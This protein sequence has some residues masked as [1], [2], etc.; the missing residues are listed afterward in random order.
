MTAGAAVQPR[1][2]VRQQADQNDRVSVQDVLRIA[3]PVRLAAFIGDLEQFA[4]YRRLLL[5][6]ED[7]GLDVVLPHCLGGGPSRELHEAAD[8]RHGVLQGHGVLMHVRSNNSC[9]RPDGG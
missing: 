7:H 1:S 6:G 2:L 3:L 4:P 9:R 8:H 5:V